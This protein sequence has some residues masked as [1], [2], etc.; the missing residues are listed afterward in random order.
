MINIYKDVNDPLMDICFAPY[1]S[2]LIL[3]FYEIQSMKICFI[4]LLHRLVKTEWDH[5]HLII[6]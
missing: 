2:I 1:R 6:I 3:I 5:R 4:T